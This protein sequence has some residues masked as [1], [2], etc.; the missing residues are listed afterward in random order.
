M[1]LK[2]AFKLLFRWTRRAALG[3]R[4][5]VYVDREAARS[6]RARRLRGAGYWMCLQ[7]VREEYPVWED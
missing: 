3:V 4:R 2:A 5:E 7:R 6:I 1:E